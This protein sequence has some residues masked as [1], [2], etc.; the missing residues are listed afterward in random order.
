MVT[1]ADFVT[2]APELA[3]VGE[4]LFGRTG[5]ALVG[6]SRKDGSP[7]ISPCEPFIID[8]DLYLGMMWQSRKAL[9]LI[10]DPRCVVHSTVSDK[11]GTDGEFKAYGRALDVPEPHR[12]ARYGDVL[13]AQTDWRP[14]EPYHLFTLDITSVGFC[15]F[16]AGK[17]VIRRW[18]PGGPEDPLEERGA[19]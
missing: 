8:G 14:S 12:R 4:E 15:R 10:R 5:L 3:V 2:E 13:E 19:P 6:T 16:G 9:D 11:E 1:W 18:R 17:Q 7:R